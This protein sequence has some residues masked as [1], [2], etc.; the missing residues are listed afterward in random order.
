MQLLQAR[1]EIGGSG[2]V[3]GGPQHIEHVGGIFES[4]ISIFDGR[5]DRDGGGE[6]DQL[7]RRAAEVKVLRQGRAQRQLADGRGHGLLTVAAEGAQHF[8]H[9]FG[10]V[11]WHDAQRIAGFVGEAR[12]FEGKL[13]V[14]HLLGGAGAAEGAHV[15]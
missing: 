14:I 12:A 9:E 15:Q 8:A 7:V 4:R 5:A 11:L 6:F 1:D 13:D 3:R 2:L 10:T